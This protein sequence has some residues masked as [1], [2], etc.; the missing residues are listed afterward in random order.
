MTR[1]GW[2]TCMTP[3][4]ALRDLEA[5]LNG[6]FAQSAQ[7]RTW[8]PAVDIEET[9][10][11]YVITAELPGMKREALQIS[12]EDNTVTVKGSCK[13]EEGEVKLLRAERRQGDF[14][15]SFQFPGGFNAE[16][17]DAVYADGILTVTVPKR[18]EDKPRQIE[19]K[20]N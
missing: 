19:V 18:E 8:R 1:T 7:P 12:A 9:E 14:E 3:A 2:N 15:R 13:R 5:H 11:S 20:F 6:V 10:Q 16:A 17:V 4:L